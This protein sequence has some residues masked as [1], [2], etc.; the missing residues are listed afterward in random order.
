MNLTSRKKVQAK[1]STPLK[2]M[3]DREDN[4]NVI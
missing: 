2:S 4:E 1:I 3:K